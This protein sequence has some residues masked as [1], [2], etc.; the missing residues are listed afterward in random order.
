MIVGRRS[1]QINPQRIKAARTFSGLTIAE[2]AE[3]IGVSR[4]AISQYEQGKNPPGLEVLMKIINVLQFPREFFYSEDPNL[5][6]KGCTFFRSSSSTLKKEKEAQKQRVNLVFH[7]QQYLGKYVNF[8]KLNLPNLEEF[9]DLEWTFQNIEKLVKTVREYW[10][11]GEE[12]IKNMVYL[13][14]KNGIF[15]TTVTT[16]EQ[17]IDAFC[18]KRSVVNNDYYF[19]VLGNDKVSAVRR[20]FD[21]AHELGHILMHSWITDEE[22]LSNDE[23]REIERQADYFAAAFLLPK[24]AFTK[25][26]YTNKLDEFIQLKK[27]WMTSIGAMVVRSYHLGIINHN[28]YSY[29]QKQMSRKGM[30]KQ[31]PLDDVLKRVT[32]SLFKQ[33]IQLLIEN[34]VLTAEKI[35]S[36][37][38]MFPH[39]IEELVNLPSGMLALN[40]EKKED[41]VI[42]LRSNNVQDK[43][44]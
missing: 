3:K 11:L 8:P 26:L 1:K 2:L 18:Q 28:Q 44:V 12:P 16:G 13:L 32:P 20:Q 17:K 41:I 22:E 43:K 5:E 40:S 27:Y 21:A 30:R 6:N 23:W 15:L 7:I 19:I 36:D 10:G 14:E 39:K 24:E 4:Q 9:Y 34:R 29:L 37:L 38:K 42:T 31:E 33:T 25:S 35:T